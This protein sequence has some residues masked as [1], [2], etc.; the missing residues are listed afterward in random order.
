MSPKGVLEA[1]VFA[2]AVAYAAARVAVE[3]AIARVNH[4]DD[5]PLPFSAKAVAFS[6]AKERLY[7]AR[8][9]ESAAWAEN[10]EA[11]R[12]LEAARTGR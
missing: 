4:D 10:F 11:Q 3:A 7:D 6:N 2:T 1:R 8:Q 5:S 9:V 12:A